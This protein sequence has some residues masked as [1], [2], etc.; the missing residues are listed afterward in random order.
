MSQQNN[1][2]ATSPTM[3]IIGAL[4]FSIALSVV[5]AEPLPADQLPLQEQLI[6][7]KKIAGTTDDAA[8][9]VSGASPSSEDPPPEESNKSDKIRTAQFVS[10]SDFPRMPPSG[11]GERL[12][13]PLPPWARG[14][15]EGA[16]PTLAPKMA[17]LEDINRQMGIYGY[18]KSKLQLSDGQKA[19]LKAIEDSLEASIG[20]LRAVCENLPNGVVGPPGIIERIDFLETQLAARLDF[21]R[22]L[23]APMQQLVGQLTPDQRALLDAPPPLHPF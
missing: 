3:R 16:P 5:G 9:T 23:K 11:M 20:K 17:C 1:T 10:H 6:P 12:G 13:P 7:S 8:V 18:T 2:Q 4:A 15:P 22:A 19:A 21:V 14:L